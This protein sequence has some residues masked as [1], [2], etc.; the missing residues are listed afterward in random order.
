[1]FIWNLEKIWAGRTNT[2]N[3][4]VNVIIIKTYEYIRRQTYLRAGKGILVPWCYWSSSPWGYEGGNHS[5]TALKFSVIMQLVLVTETYVT[6]MMETLELVVILEVFS[7][8]A[9]GIIRW[10]WCKDAGMAKVKSP[11]TP[12]WLPEGQLPW[13]VTRSLLLD[14]VWKNNSLVLCLTTGVLLNYN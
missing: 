2:K 6:S 5:F 7:S 11:W 9:A 14:F 3:I 8:K 13:R 4:N 10:F 1:M 12:L